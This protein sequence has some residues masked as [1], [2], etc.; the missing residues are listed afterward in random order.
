VAQAL[1][2]SLPTAERYWA[3]ART[4]LYAELTAGE[5]PAGEKTVAP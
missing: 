1:G 5:P 2:I 4:W 3:F